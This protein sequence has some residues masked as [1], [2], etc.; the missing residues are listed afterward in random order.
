MQQVFTMKNMKLL[1]ETPPLG[2]RINAYS[3]FNELAHGIA[4]SFMVSLSNLTA[5]F[6]GA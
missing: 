1:K 6:T 2:T 3:F 5:L 4:R